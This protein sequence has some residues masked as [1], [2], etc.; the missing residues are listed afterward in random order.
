[1]A[2]SALLAVE[3]L[4]QIPFLGVN[5]LQAAMGAVGGTAAALAWHARRTW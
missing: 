5:G 1:M 2:A 4:I 3:L